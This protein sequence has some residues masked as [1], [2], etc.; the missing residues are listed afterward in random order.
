[1]KS[2][3]EE[4]FYGNVGQN[5]GC[6][7]ASAEEQQLMEY[8]LAH[9][10]ELKKTLTD[11]QKELLEK[12]EEC[13]AELASLHERQVFVYAFRLGMRMAKEVFCPEYM[14]ERKI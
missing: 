14:S 5:A 11:K 3:L 4:L 1:M 9:H 8:L 2:I 13:D 6:R 10:A 12:Y 7:D